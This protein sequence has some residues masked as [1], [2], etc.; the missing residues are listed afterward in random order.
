MFQ[1]NN[2][3]FIAILIVCMCVLHW[4]AL[5]S[6]IPEVDQ[7]GL[8]LG[9]DNVAVLV[10]ETTTLNCMTDGVV[11]S[12]VRWIEYVTISGTGSIITDGTNMVPGHPNAAR[13]ELIYDGDRTYALKISNINL[14]DAGYYECVD[15]NAAPP[16]YIRFGAQLVVLGNN[17]MLSFCVVYIQPTGTSLCRT[18]IVRCLQL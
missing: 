4:T 17:S 14:D 16:S 11:N 5:G 13:Y 7:R 18:G 8:E 1:C 12:N 6:V 3:P 9:P 2:V 10:G 15:S